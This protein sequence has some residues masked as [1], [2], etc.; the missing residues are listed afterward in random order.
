MSRRNRRNRNQA[1]SS[2]AV[3]AKAEVVPSRDVRSRAAFE[4]ARRVVATFKSSTPTLQLLGDR[5]I[6]DLLWSDQDRVIAE[7]YHL[8]K[9]NGLYRGCI[10]RVDNFVVGCEG[11]RV[12]ASH[13]AVQ[14][15]L[16]QF[17][18]EGLDSLRD[19][20]SM[21]DLTQ[22]RYGE[23][24]LPTFAGVDRMLSFGYK[25]PLLI[26]ENLADP[27]DSQTLVQ[28]VMKKKPG[29]PEQRY[30]LI[31][32]DRYGSFML[33]LPE[34]QSFPEGPLGALYFAPNRELDGTRGHPPWMAA[35]A[36]FDLAQNF[37]FSAANRSRILMNILLHVQVKGDDTEAERI[38]SKFDLEGAPEPESVEVTNEAVEFKWIT[39]E[40]AAADAENVYYLILHEIAHRTQLPLHWLIKGE[41]TTYAS[42]RDISYPTF[43]MLQ[44]MQGNF[45]RVVRTMCELQIDVAER[46]GGPL[47]ALAPEDRKFDVTLP[48]VIPDDPS[49]KLKNMLDLGTVLAAAQVNGW[50]RPE[51]LAMVWKRKAAAEGLDVEEAERELGPAAIPDA[52]TKAAH[53]ALN[54]ESIYAEVMARYQEAQQQKPR[55]AIPAQRM[56]SLPG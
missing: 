35:H 26:A 21:Y 1:A 45:L 48:E 56:L 11:P 33:D 53:D 2:P 14:E 9:N 38:R 32:R 20:F 44:R 16:D 19:R 49:A 55:T 24:L 4:A 28:S 40:L 54:A 25:N 15:L 31:R 10:E 47:R 17:I 39:P 22:L 36:W 46:P 12:K 42:A 23:L 27:D 18:G 50:A 13:P 37:L 5:P 6:S 51:A 41:E 3:P 8:S 29:E 34:G 7:A 43:K 30:K 52:R